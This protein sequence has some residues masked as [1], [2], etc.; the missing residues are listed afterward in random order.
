VGVTLISVVSSVTRNG[1]GRS[2]CTRCGQSPSEHQF[3]E[4]GECPPQQP[5]FNLRMVTLPGFF[6]EV[7][8]PRTV[9]EIYSA[10]AR[11]TPK[12]FDGS[13]EGVYKQ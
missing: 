6:S 5:E 10:R 9:G 7:R 11:P 8:F 2:Q 13:V 3:Q 4:F 12:G 1:K